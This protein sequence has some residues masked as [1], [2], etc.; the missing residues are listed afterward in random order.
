MNNETYV[1]CLVARKPSAILNFL[2]VLLIMLAVAFFLVGFVTNVGLIGLIVAIIFAVLAYFVN[3][4]SDV[5]FEYLYLDKE[6]IIDKVS[7]K[8]KRKRVATYSIE[9]MEILAPIASYHLDNYKNRQGEV[10]DYSS[11]T[12]KQ[13][14]PRFVMYYEGGMKVIFEPSEAFVKAVYNVAPRKVFKD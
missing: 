11:N 4:K 6:I 13:P 10:K 5:E 2:K 14:D 1:E 12:P 9:R 7:A 8:S 3:L